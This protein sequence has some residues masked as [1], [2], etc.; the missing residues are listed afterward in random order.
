[1]AELILNHARANE[2]RDVP[3]FKREMAQLVDGALST[4]TLSLGKVCRALS[5]RETLIGFR[6]PKGRTKRT[7]ESFI[8]LAI[9]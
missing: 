1:M 4:N 2:C 8:P 6:G 3:R 9:H 7:R 5:T